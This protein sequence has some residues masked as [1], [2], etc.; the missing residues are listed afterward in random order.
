MPGQVVISE[1]MV[2]PTPAV[3]LPAVEYIELHNQGDA[4][5]LLQRL[6]IRSGTRRVPLTDTP[7]DSLSPGAY[8][9]L[10]DTDDVALF[11]SLAVQVQGIDLPGLTN[12]RDEVSLYV[13]NELSST[14]Q[15]DESWYKSA[16]RSKGG[17]SLEYNG[18]GTVNCSGSW[19][20]SRDEQGGTPGRA[21]SLLGQLLDTVPPHVVAAIASDSGLTVRFDEAVFGELEFLFELDG[22]STGAFRV[23]ERTAFVPATL[24]VGRLYTLRI[25][26]EYADCTGN[27][28][29]AAQNLPVLRP[30][31]LQTGDVLLSEVLFDP[32]P[33]GSDFVEVYN[34]SG[35]SIR[36]ADLVLSNARQVQR[37]ISTTA[38]LPP[39]GYFV[40]T[41]DALD[42]RSRFPSTDIDRVAEIDLPSLPNEG[43]TIRIETAAG[44]TIDA[45]SY[46]DDMHA[47]LVDAEG[48]SL[49]RRSFTAPT[50]EAAN[51]ATAASTAGYGT[52]TQ[53][54]S[55]QADGTT[56]AV[57]VELK[58]PT[59]SPD[60]DGTAD[61]LAL[62]YR[63]DRPGYLARVTVFDAAGR[64][65]HTQPRSELLG[66][67]GTLHWDGRDAVGVVQAA[68]P[69]VVLV[70]LFHP[71]GATTTRKLVAILAS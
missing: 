48:A 12:T 28:P 36:L 2:D 10:V 65:V 32:V 61:E 31:A 69:Y 57:T 53:P 66:T 13:D 37:T 40:F 42:L 68:G 23:D 35:N 45:F 34:A 30:A 38:I 5:I 20:A 43:G 17:Y 19:A 54:N 16:D 71:D 25:A 50:Q 6:A 46:S 55:Q 11:S 67:S 56:P 62:N 22:V 58:E 63:T 26:P 49:E 70:Q 9:L 52:P 44:L 33:G 24:L 7:E 59:F 27:S 41:A 47:E 18:G 64:P 8:L 4:A 21:N 51:W 15:Y 39:G 14:V 3:G 60:G 1:L 29:S